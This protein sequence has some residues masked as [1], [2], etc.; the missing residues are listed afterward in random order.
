MKKRGRDK[1]M[2]GGGRKGLVE[3]FWVSYQVLK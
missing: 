1:G 2:G 3:L